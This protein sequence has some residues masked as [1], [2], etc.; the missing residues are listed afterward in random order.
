MLLRVPTMEDFPAWAALREES[1][2]FLVPWEPSWPLD[3]LTKASFRRRLRYY[4]LDRRQGVGMAFFVFRIEDNALLGSFSLSH[5]RRGVSQSAN[6]GYWIGQPYA[7]QGYGAE[8]LTAVVSY[9]FS[10]LG[11]NRLEAATLPDNIPSQTLLKKIG[12]VEEGFARRYLKI[13]GKWSDHVLFGLV[14]DD[15]YALQRAK[16]EGQLA[17]SILPLKN[18]KAGL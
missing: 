16:A 18:L 14:Q 17:S 15:Y 2:D 5:L 13:N 1:R 10:R 3:G 4:A 9:S 12:F 11:L 7:N 8:A 6:L